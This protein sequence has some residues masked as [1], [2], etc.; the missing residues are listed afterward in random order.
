MEDNGDIVEDPAEIE[1]EEV[2]LD[3]RAVWLS[4]RA[5]QVGALARHLVIVRKSI[6]SGD[7]PAQLE[8]LL[9]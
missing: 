2:P 8:A 4:R 9:G 3:D 5:G 6:D 7:I 1:V